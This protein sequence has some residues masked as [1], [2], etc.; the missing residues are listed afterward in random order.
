[1]TDRPIIFSAPMVQAL[2]ARRK[3][4]TRRLA[5]RDPYASGLG[6]A[7]RTPSPWQKVQP[8]D[9]LWVR[10]AWGFQRACEPPYCLQTALPNVPRP[11]GGWTTPYYR[12]D[13]EDSAWGMYG[14][15]Q[16]RSPI[17]M[18]RSASRLTLTVTATRVERLQA[19]TYE[20]VTAE[21]IETQQFGADLQ[22]EGFRR[23]RH[24]DG[25]FTPHAKVAFLQL[26][27]TIHGPDAWDAN[28]EVVRICF[29]C[30]LG[31]IDAKEAA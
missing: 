31:N 12:A 8:G 26:W 22:S 25:R 24:P 17:H 30:R 1:M 14:P 7:N 9:R 20:D 19:I 16:W 28:P 10:E 11:G 15:P 23:W 2:L 27:N 29:D 18:P 5:W 3:T 21:G 6:G 4:M 13:T